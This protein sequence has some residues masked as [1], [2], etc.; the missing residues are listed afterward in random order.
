VLVQGKTKE[1]K[2][3]VQSMEDKPLEFHTY[4]TELNYNIRANIV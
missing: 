4:T 1:V 3:T 2:V